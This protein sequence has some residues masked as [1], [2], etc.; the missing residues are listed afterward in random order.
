MAHQY[1]LPLHCRHRGIV[2]GLFT[3]GL[4]DLVRRSPAPTGPMVSGRRWLWAAHAVGGTA[5]P[6]LSLM[7]W[8]APPTS[9]STA[10]PMWPWNAAQ[11]SAVNLPDGAGT[12]HRRQS[13]HRRTAP[14]GRKGAPAV[15]FGVHV[16][17]RV[18]ERFDDLVTVAGRRIDQRGVS[19]PA[20]GGAA[21]G[22]SP[23]RGTLAWAQ[24][25]KPI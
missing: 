12:A 18:D 3:V 7:V 8:L 25:P 17:A 16:G 10:A 11:C 19:T 2:L 9:S 20:H 21:K 22:V 6:S 13:G 4:C 23:A 1:T 15:V 14:T 5:Y 24:Q